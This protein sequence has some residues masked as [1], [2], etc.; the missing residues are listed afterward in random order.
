[1]TGL[2]RALAAALA[3]TA[4]GPREDP[5]TLV[6]R[7]G[8]VRTLA[9]DATP[10]AALAV[11]GDRIVYLGDDAGVARWVGPETEVVELAGRLVLPGFHDTHVHALDGG[12]GQADCDLHAASTPAAL[13]DAV[14]DCAER[15][16]GAP[17]IRGGGWD[18]TLFESG[19]P[20]RALLDSLIPDRPVYLTDATE[21]AAWVN[22]RALEIAG[23]DAGTRSPDGGGVIVRSPDGSPQGTLRESAMELVATH[24]PTRTDAELRAGLDRALALAASLGITTLHEASADEATLRAYA[25]AEAVDPLSA[26]VR[27]FVRVDPARGAGQVGDIVARRDRFPARLARIAGAKIFLDGVLEGGTAALLEPY[28]DRRSWSG[29]LRAPSSDSL[30]ALVAGLEAAGLAAHF[31][32]IGDR[33]VRVALDAIEAGGSRTRARHVIAHLQLVDPADL[34]RFF[35]LG[36]VASVQPLWAQRDAYITDLTEPR[37]GP[38]RSGR[39]YPIRSVLASG[40]VVA[41][42][43]DWPVTTMDP[44]DAIEVAVTRRNE[45]AAAGPSWIPEERL[46]VEDAVRAYTVAGAYAAGMEVDTGMLTVGRLADIVVLDQDIFEVEPTEISETTVE[47]TV[48]EGRIVHRRP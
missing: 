18:P 1:V 3:V 17:W 19:E 35:E 39:L 13:I 23:I 27:L 16:G 14:R 47:L 6:L 31:H 30:A 29:D 2:G 24:L 28:L 45:A 37:V 25:D 26:R 22:G 42:G 21:H 8:V 15:A 34:P 10:V 38:E 43:S 11:R 40:A 4:C 12:V 41:A 32:A 44:L 5:A 46:T 36:V 9:P 33:A 20:A 48:M 7:G